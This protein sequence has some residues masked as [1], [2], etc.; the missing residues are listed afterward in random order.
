MLAQQHTEK[1]NEIIYHISHSLIVCARVLIWSKQ[2]ICDKSE[3]HGCS[4]WKK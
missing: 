3:L 1:Q 2:G 4:L